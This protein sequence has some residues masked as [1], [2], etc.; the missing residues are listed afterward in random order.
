VQ[1]T[2]PA[3]PGAPYGKTV[4]VKL[5]LDVAPFGAVAVTTSG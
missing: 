4:N 2:S 1:K 5:T 3:P